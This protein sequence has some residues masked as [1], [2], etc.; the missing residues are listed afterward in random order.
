MEKMCLLVVS[1]VLHIGMATAGAVPA[2]NTFSAGATSSAA[3]VNAN[4]SDVKT[5]VDDNDA[6]VTVLEAAGGTA[7]PGVFTDVSAAGNQ[8]GCMQTAEQG[9]GTWE[10]A[11]NT[12]F[13][14]FGGRLPTTGEWYIT[15]NNFALTGEINGWEWNHDGA[16]TTA[17]RHA[18]SGGLD[19]ATQTIAGDVSAYSYRCWIP[20]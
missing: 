8:L 5:A 6:R 20:R 11:S 7:C 15:M 16:T 17:D 10:T 14:T 9:T 13:T 1:M 2:L 12:C 19:L 4:F 18:V 3:Q